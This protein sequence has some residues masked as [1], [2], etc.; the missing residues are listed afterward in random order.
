MREDGVVEAHGVAHDLS[1]GD[2]DHAAWE[3]A[4]PV[5]IARLWSGEDA[6]PAR[7]AESRLL[8]TAD[9]LLVRFVCRQEEPLIVNAA[10]EVHRKTIGLWDRD[11]CELFV[12]PHA[13]APQRYFEFE[14]APTGEWLDLA[15]EKTAGG[16]VT[17]W[18]YS[19]GMTV[20]ARAGEGQLT[21]AMR[22]PF[23]ALG[24]KPARNDVWRANLYRCVGAGWS[25]Y[26]AWLPTYTPEPNFHVP[27]K[28]GRLKF[29]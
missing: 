27:E 11:V 22:V 6:P 9:A 21:L 13:H 24:R 18:D 28:F 29:T 7:H 17:D 23:A 12:A 26:L 2:L 16:R 20:A 3:D 5:G 14:V 10:P 15:L 25:R 19:S 4:R 1:A 8:W